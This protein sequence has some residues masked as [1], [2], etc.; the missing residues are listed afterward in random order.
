M[1]EPGQTLAV[2]CFEAEGRKLSNE[3]GQ[4]FFGPTEGR[5]IAMARPIFE[6]KRWEGSGRDPPFC[7]FESIILAESGARQ[8]RNFAKTRYEKRNKSLLSLL[9]AVLTASFFVFGARLIY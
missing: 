7:R 9:L 2:A 5:L 4:Q 3:V 8:P 6:A 1:A